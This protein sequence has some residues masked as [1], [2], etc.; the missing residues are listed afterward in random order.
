MST[1]VTV[2]AALTSGALAVAALTRQPR[3]RLHWTFALGMIGFAA[4]ALATCVLL[5]QTTNPEAR[6]WSLQALEIARLALVAPWAL[7]AVIVLRQ[8]PAATSRAARYAPLAWLAALAVSTATVVVVPAYE[9]SDVE[10]PFYAARLTA[11]G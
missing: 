2:L 7:F 8:E 5:T 4:E 9:V 1:I 11:S 3:G 6:R 10:A